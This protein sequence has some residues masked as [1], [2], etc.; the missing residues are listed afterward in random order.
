M[1]SWPQRHVIGVRGHF[2]RFISEV[3]RIK[4]VLVEKNIQKAQFYEILELA[5]NDEKMQKM[6]MPVIDPGIAEPGIE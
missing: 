6:T 3:Y 1:F 2:E 5:K 4:F